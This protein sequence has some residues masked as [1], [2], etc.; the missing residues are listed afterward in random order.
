MTEREVKIDPR[1]EMRR[2]M[3][4]GATL[5]VLLCGGVG[6]WA[7][8][9]EISGAVIAPGVVVV[10][11]NVR[12]VQHPTGGVV[13]EICARDGDR[14]SAGEVALRLDETV[15]RANLAIVTKGID[16]F[17]ARKSRLEAERDGTEVIAFPDDF[18]ARVNDQNVVVT[19]AGERKLFELRR[20]HDRTAVAAASA[21][22]ATGR[23]D[24]RTAGSSSG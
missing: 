5:L 10:D 12:K 7:A 6:G 3:R 9:A 13:A 4:A 8:S 16:Q 2:L 21:H 23:G 19:I 22:L 15:P 24:R 1:G 20:L 11:S 14:V 18:S 17:V